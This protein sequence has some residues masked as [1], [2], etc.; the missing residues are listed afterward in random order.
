MPLWPNR[1]VNILLPTTRQAETESISPYRAR[2]GY[3]GLE[4][5]L[6]RE[7]RE[8]VENIAQSGL[9]GRGGAAFPAGRKWQLS[10][11][12]PAQVRYIVVNG[13]EDEP[14]SFKDRYLMQCYP[15]LVLEGALIAAYAIQAQ[16]IFL[17]VNEAFDAAQASLKCA[18]EE[19]TNSD[20]PKDFR[21]AFQLFPAPQTYV[22]GED[23]AA[24]EVLEGKPPIPRKKPPYPAES[25][26]RGLPTLVH[27][28]ETLAHVPFIMREGADRYRKIGTAASPGTML[29]YLN[30]DFVRPG[31]YE[32]PFGTPLRH[33][34]EKVGGGLK[35]GKRLK[36]ILPGGPSTAF[37]P[38]AALDLPLE[39]Q[40][41]KDS[42]SSLGCGN[43][44]LIPEEACMVEVSLEIAEFF[45]RESCGKCPQCRMETNIFVTILKKILSGE[46]NE[47][48][49]AQIETV[50]TFSRGKGDCGL[51]H[52]AATPLLSALRHFRE[53]FQAH[54]AK[55][56]C[57]ARKGEKWPTRK[58][59]WSR[60]T[61]SF[62]SS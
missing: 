5:S 8:I 28:V 31:I 55:K 46:G 34:V 40:A 10:A 9:Q 13:A 44:R 23:S 24:L 54:V 60:T 37:L 58:F 26:Y 53:D 38:A 7:P 52:M 12:T 17:Y 42:G 35:E 30:E 21:P 36:A 14:G 59:S 32:L 45:A 22:A 3:L 62:V 33:L 19:L 51:I 47:A 15:H 57:D 2:G 48:A 61:S 20:L 16:H 41:F 18:L 49:L 43:I 1:I 4:R 11:R 39:H 6:G 56:T 25:G 50:A 27:N 29:F